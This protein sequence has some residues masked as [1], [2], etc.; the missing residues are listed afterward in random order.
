MMSVR[1][2]VGKGMWIYIDMDNTAKI[3]LL[4]QE[5]KERGALIVEPPDDKPWD[6]R[7]IL[8]RP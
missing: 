4:Y 7:E 1:E 5:F 3:E 6:M 2:Q 8:V